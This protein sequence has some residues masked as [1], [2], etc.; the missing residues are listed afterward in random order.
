MNLRV[1]ALRALPP[2]HLPT[3]VPIL[4]GRKRKRDTWHI[5]NCLQQDISCN[6][7]NDRSHHLSAFWSC[8][9]P[10]VL[11]VAIRLR[12]T[13][14]HNQSSTMKSFLLAAL[15]VMLMT[16]P[17]A[18]FAFSPSHFPTKFHISSSRLFAKHAQKA[19]AHHEKWQ[20]YF[21]RLEKFREEHGS[22]KDLPDGDLADWLQ[23]QRKQYHLL[24]QGKKV[25]L[26][27]KR[28]MA[29]ER[30]GAI[31]SDDDLNVAP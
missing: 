19:P 21:D 12:I 30:A 28:A 23:D 1:Q 15:L 7:K 4:L 20:P 8:R 25:R 17:E 5:E 14:F 13:L 24:Q 2:L 27:K 31:Q 22:Y 6:A 16:R 18:S 11:P 9:I 26:T 10:L 3:R 29:L